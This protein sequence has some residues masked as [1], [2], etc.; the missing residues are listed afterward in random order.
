MTYSE[1]IESERDELAA[2]SD[3]LDDAIVFL[4]IDGLFSDPTARL[5]YLDKEDYDKFYGCAMASDTVHIDYTTTAAVLL[6][7]QMMYRKVE[8]VFLTGRPERTRDLTVLWLKQNIPFFKDY[9]V[10]NHMIMR[11]DQDHRVG[12]KMKWDGMSDYITQVKVDELNKTDVFFI[13]DD[14]RNIKYCHQKARDLIDVSIDK[15]FYL[16]G[17]VLGAQRLPSVHAVSSTKELGEN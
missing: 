11:D 8:W 13:D 4:D 12:F 14:Y 6:G 5:P 17:I 7:L 16:H 10:A 1:L 15:G 2:P 9:D 3:K